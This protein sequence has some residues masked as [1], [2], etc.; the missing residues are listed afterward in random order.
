MDQ[1]I[2]PNDMS[3]PTTLAPGRPGF[4]RSSHDNFRWQL[5]RKGIHL[6]EHCKEVQQNSGK[7]TYLTD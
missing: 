1:G 7:V 6:S 4:D 2:P 5:I 3:S